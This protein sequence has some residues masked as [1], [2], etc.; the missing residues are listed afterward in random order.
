VKAVSPDDLSL[1]VLVLLRERLPGPCDL[2]V[3]LLMRGDPG[4]GRTAASMAAELGTPKSW[5]E[6]ALD[7]LCAAGLL[8]EDGSATERQFFYRP[9]TA[10]LE[11]TMSALARAYEERPADVVRMMND[12]AIAR[13]RSA[14]VQLFP[15]SLML[16]KE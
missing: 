11:T 3:L 4:R 9:A 14:A 5:V 15:A 8:V 10:N 13:V 7:D 1:D 16:R 12:N 6:Q 2:E